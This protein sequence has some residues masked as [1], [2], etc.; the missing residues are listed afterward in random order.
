MIEA[1][2]ERRHTDPSLDAWPPPLSKEVR[3]RRRLEVETAQTRDLV[4]KVCAVRPGRIAFMGRVMWANRVIRL[5]DAFYTT[6]KTKELTG[7]D[8][9]RRRFTQRNDTRAAFAEAEIAVCL[10]TTVV[11]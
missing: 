8:T 5:S 7:F 11:G 4:V 6:F 2:T 1:L 10:Y 3:S 9:L